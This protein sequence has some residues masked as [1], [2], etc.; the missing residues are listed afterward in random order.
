M[1]EPTR[2]NASEL[3]D[4]RPDLSGELQR[5]GREYKLIQ[6]GKLRSGGGFVSRRFP[7]F[8]GLGGDRLAFGRRVKRDGCK[9]E[10][11]EPAVGEDKYVNRFP[12][13]VEIRGGGGGG[14]GAG[15]GGRRPGE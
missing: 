8:E 15:S 13:R 6:A 9:L 4:S 14:G 10:A 1:S 3:G 2:V 7:P 11:T 5:D 12:C